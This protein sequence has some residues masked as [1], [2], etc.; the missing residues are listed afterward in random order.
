MSGLKPE[1]Q[2][3]LAVLEN[4]PDLDGEFALAGAAAT[5]T[6]AT[7]LDRRNAIKTT[8]FRAERPVGPNDSL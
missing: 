6:N 5:Q 4:G 8:A 3:D 1:V 7:A 2:F